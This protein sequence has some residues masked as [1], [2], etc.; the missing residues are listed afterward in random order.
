MRSIIEQKD[1]D[2]DVIINMFCTNFKL[3]VDF[4]QLL[5]VITVLGF[6]IYLNTSLP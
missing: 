4:V 5:K 6:T 3:S 1:P 2:S